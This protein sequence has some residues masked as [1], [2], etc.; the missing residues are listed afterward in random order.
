MPHRGADR[1]LRSAE[2]RQCREYDPSEFHRSTRLAVPE[3]HWVPPELTIRIPA[4][5]LLQRAASESI[6]RSVH[7]G[8]QS[9][10]D[11]QAFRRASNACRRCASHPLADHCHGRAVPKRKKGCAHPANRVPAGM[12]LSWKMAAAGVSSLISRQSPSVVENNHKT[13]S[14]VENYCTAT[15]SKF[16]S[17]LSKIT[18][19]PNRWSK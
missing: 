15:E 18:R 5:A 7:A 16:H 10:G 3:F 12:V 8:K 19:K 4:V 9:S 13:L 17:L 11:R 1:R 6:N 14:G 2:R